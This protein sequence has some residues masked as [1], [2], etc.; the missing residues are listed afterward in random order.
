MVQA[1]I[2]SP[3]VHS[4]LGNGLQICQLQTNHCSL[5]MAHVNF[6]WFLLV[7]AA[8]FEFVVVECFAQLPSYLS[9]PAQT[10]AHLGSHAGKD[11]EGGVCHGH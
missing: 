7:Q 4:P 2:Q 6:D 11:I 8:P 3:V 10:G 9:R 1:N 5:G